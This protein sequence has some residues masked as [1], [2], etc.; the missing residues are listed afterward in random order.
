M[1]CCYG[2]PLLESVQALLGMCDL[3]L[4]MP[5]MVNKK[6]LLEIYGR[7]AAIVCREKAMLLAIFFLKI[8]LEKSSAHRFLCSS[9]L[10]SASKMSIL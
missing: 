1:D 3:H 8:Q 9:S 5:T 4:L 6:V 7:N 10:A 2:I